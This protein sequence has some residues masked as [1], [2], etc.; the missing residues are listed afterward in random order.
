VHEPELP[1]VS[2]VTP[3]FNQVPFLEATIHSV[4]SQDYPRV[5]YILI[6]GGSTDGSLDL[7]RRYAPKLAYWVSEPDLGQTDAI[8]KGFA[9]ARGEIFAW[10]NSDD[11]YRPGAISEAVAYLG[12]HREIGMVYGQAF[13]VDEAGATIA[14]Y[15][16]GPTDHRGLRRG[17]TTIPQQASFFRSRL[18]RMVG[19]LDPSFYYAMDYDL[20]VRL[21]AV[22][23]IAYAAT[24]GGLS[25]HDLSKS[26]RG[27]PLLAG[28]DEVHFRDGGSDIHPTPNTLCAE[29]SSR[30]CRGMTLRR[31]AYALERPAVVRPDSSG[32]PRMF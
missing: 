7:I 3:S 22:S 28:N 25:I 2:V 18:W 12:T 21:S 6:D 16:A 14:R 17:N 32:R 13:Y 9:V 31:W 29:S 8:N 15:P 30:S 5:E 23:P 24:L 26:R 20:W 11:V 27:L 1:L 19:P 10:L 4:L